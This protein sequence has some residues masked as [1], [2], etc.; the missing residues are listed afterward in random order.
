M[1]IELEKARTR[2]NVVRIFREDLD[3][4]DNWTDGFVIDA[5]EEMVLLQLVDDGVHLNGYQIL[6]LEDIS[7]F[8]HPAPFNDFQKRVLELRDEEI[9]DPD[10]DLDDLAVL[11]VDISEE[12][13][14]VTLHREE[15]EP[16]SCEIGRVVRADAVSFEL[17]EIGS[18]A[19]WFDETFEYDLYDITR[20]EFGSSYEEALVLAND[21]MGEDAY[22]LAEKYEEES[23]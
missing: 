20:I 21:D 7:D 5:N 4:P 15:V 23:V 19:R 16:D 8:V 14:L 22:E 9:E 12:F 2:K 6:F 1:L 18:D 11:L 17:E 3:G 10:V 13:G